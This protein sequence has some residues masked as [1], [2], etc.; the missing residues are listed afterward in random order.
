MDYVLTPEQEREL[1]MLKQ[2]YGKVRTM[3]VPLDE[4]DETKYAILFLKKPD[5]ATRN[6]TWSFVQKGNTDAAIQACLKA[7][8]IGGDKLDLIFSNDDAM[9]AVDLTL[10][11]LL[12]TQKAVLKKN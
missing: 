3:C 5:R 6:M 8:W 4:D 1:E 2:K 7:L 11:E 12:K 10:T 9:E